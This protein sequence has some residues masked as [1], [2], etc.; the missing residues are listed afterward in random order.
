MVYNPYLQAAQG[1]IPPAEGQLNLQTTTP[2]IYQ[3]AQQAVEENVYRS[4]I[5][6]M[7]NRIAETDA[8]NQQNGMSVPERIIQ[9]LLNVLKHV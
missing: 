9:K 5:N 6:P 4:R 3:Q 1:Q 7:N 2:D 8:Y